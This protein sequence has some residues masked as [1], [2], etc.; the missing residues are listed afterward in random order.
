MIKT[1]TAMIDEDKMKILMAKEIRAETLRFSI[2][3]YLFY[4][5][6]LFFSA[7]GS[8][9]AQATIGLLESVFPQGFGSSYL[10]WRNSTD[11]KALSDVVFIQWQEEVQMQ[12]IFVGT[13]KYL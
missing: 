1:K 3:A 8:D 6:F 5:P 10:I 11:A 9:T 4:K 12:T 7:G 2:N 13:Y